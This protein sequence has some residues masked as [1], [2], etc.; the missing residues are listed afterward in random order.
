MPQCGGALDFVVTDL[1]PPD[2][3]RSYGVRSVAL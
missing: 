3:L 1:F 2:K